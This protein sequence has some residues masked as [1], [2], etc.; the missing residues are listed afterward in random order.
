MYL[1]FS[2]AVSIAVMCLIYGLPGDLF[3]KPRWNGILIYTNR[4]SE[5]V[6]K[7]KFIVLY[8]PLLWS[9]GSMDGMVFY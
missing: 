2:S 8:S 4:I 3:I 5:L 9:S 1:I 6:S 7:G